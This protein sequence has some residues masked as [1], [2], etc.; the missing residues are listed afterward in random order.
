MSRERYRLATYSLGE[1][2]DSMKKCHPER[3]LS[4]FHRER[5]S[6]R[7]CGWL[8]APRLS[9]C[10]SACP[11][12]TSR[13]ICRY[14]LDALDS[15]QESCKPILATI[16]PSLRWGTRFC[17]RGATAPFHRVLCS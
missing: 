13:L 8:I 15:Y 16:K 4:R 11:V 2:L 10:F 14:V 5:R 3:S 6:R 7:T 17:Y 12:R 1:V 9:L